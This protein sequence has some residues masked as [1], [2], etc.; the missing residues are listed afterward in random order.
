M[1][2]DIGGGFAQADGSA[3]LECG[4]TKVKA[5]VFGPTHAK[6][7]AAS[8][9]EKASIVAEY[10]TATF[11]TVDRKRKSKGDRQ[12]QERGLW[13]Q[14]VFEDAIL[15]EQFPRSQIE[16]YVEILQQDGSPVSTAINAVT[17]ALIDAGIPMRDMVVSTTVGA[18]DNK[19][20]LV[21][22]NHAESEKAA[23]AAQLVMAVYS[24]SFQLILCEC[25]SKLPVSSFELAYEIGQEACKSAALTLRSFTV[26]NAHKR[27][28][29][30]QSLVKRKNPLS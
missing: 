3:Y 1:S 4:L 11:G 2:A 30:L 28:S 9:T 27:I 21:D 22:L 16:I 14:R 13:I 12:S 5:Y 10:M 6:R 25:E 23:G 7:R 15:T 26:E 8:G 18:I 17:L 20:I 24:R 19:T 29:S